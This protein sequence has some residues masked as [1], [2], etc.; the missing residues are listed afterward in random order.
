MRVAQLD[1]HKLLKSPIEFDTAIHYLQFIENQFID[2]ESVSEQWLDYMLAT[3]CEVLSHT[4]DLRFFRP[5]F[6]QACLTIA[7][8][9]RGCDCVGLWVNDC[10]RMVKEALLRMDHQMSEREAEAVTSHLDDAKSFVEDA[11]NFVPGGREVIVIKIESH[12]FERATAVVN[13]ESSWAS[14]LLNDIHFFQ[15]LMR[16]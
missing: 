7:A 14:R 11:L 3:V 9:K 12:V 5:S 6:A 15:S 16:E 10:V 2:T 1:L 13:Q 8:N 4:D